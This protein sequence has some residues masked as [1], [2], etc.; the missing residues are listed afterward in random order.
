MLT[1]I[2]K[3]TPGPRTAAVR[4]ERN[5]VSAVVVALL[6]GSCANVGMA[7]AA[8]AEDL[9]PVPEVGSPGMI[10][11]SSSVHPLVFPA[12]AA[13]QSYSWQI[14]ITLDG[15]QSGHSTLQLA[16]TGSLTGTGG[17][18]IEIDKC[19][20]L[21]A[22]VSGLGQALSCP[23]GAQPV[24][25]LQALSAVKQGVSLPLEE[26]TAGTSWYLRATLQR[27]AD[28]LAQPNEPYLRLGIGISAF[29]D[30]P[31]HRRP[32]LS[33]TGAQ[34]TPILWLAGGLLAAGGMV[35]T[36]RRRREGNS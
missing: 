24:V 28:A 10:A 7:T 12:L 19:P 5:L 26:L 3:G 2:I 14:G 34:T 31:E 8:D 29:G 36:A 13:G 25:P 27:P 32:G 18:Q 1:S 9:K 20:S 21:W 30:E 17:Y 35:M 16:A 15:P 23:S 33:Q 6:A 11:L 22:G 4:L